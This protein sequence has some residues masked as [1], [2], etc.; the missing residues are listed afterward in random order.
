MSFDD[1]WAEVLYER[2]TLP[3][4]PLGAPYSRLFNVLETEFHELDSDVEFATFKP[5]RMHYVVKPWR[6]EE[7]TTKVFITPHRGC[8]AILKGG[9][10]S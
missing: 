4:D 10:N 5:K 1:S 8:L 2:R 7:Y 3:T 6:L 9:V